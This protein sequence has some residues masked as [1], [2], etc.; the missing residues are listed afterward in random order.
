MTV[1]DIFT[2]SAYGRS[3][4]FERN[5]EVDPVGPLIVIIDGRDA[6]VRQA[7]A[8]K[9]RDLLIDL[10]GEKPEPPPYSARDKFA[11]LEVGTKFRSTRYRNSTYIK[12]TEYDYWVF[13]TGYKSSVA[14]MSDRFEFE[15][16]G[17]D[18]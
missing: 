6:I 15:V 8:E 7:D 9:L 10:V 12:L 16:E 17:I 5:T 18:Y 13:N 4:V 1:P 11:T 3:L 14:H 2:T